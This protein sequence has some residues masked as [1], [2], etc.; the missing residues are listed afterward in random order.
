ML[1]PLQ[2][3]AVSE[4]AG[5]GLEGTVAGTRYFVGSRRYIEEQG[6]S[7][8]PELQPLL[9]A[10]AAEGLTTSF[11]AREGELLALLQLSDTLRPSAASALAALRQQGK[12]LIL[13]TGDN[14]AVARSVAAQLGIDEVVASVLPDGK[15]D[16]VAR[17][18]AAGHRV[19][20]LGDGVNDAAALARADLRLAMGQGGLRFFANR[21]L[22]CG[23]RFRLP[24]G[25]L[26]GRLRDGLRRR[27]RDR[28]RWG[29]ECVQRV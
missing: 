22:G 2:L 29:L 15:A 23:C 28:L 11:F 10:A 5:R 4:R 9:E 14:E 24:R 21:R 8:S 18:Q 26:G 25:R 6:I 1:Q 20:M 19:A 16:Y 13:L 17:L 3:T 7:L 12:R 27:W